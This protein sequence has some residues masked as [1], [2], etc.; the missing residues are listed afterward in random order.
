M[1][2]FCTTDAL[3]AVTVSVTDGVVTRR[4]Y[5]DTG[6]PIPASN[7][8]FSTVEALFDIIGSAIAR[9]A[10]RVDVSYDPVRGVPSRISI[11]GSFQ[12]ADDEVWYSVRDF[13]AR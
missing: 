6:E 8:T 2:C 7:N 12:V 13:R 3:R 4:V 9:H 11:D 5:A 10:Q 1:S